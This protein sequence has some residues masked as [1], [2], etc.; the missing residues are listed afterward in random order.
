MAKILLHTLVFSPDSVSTSYL[1][2]DIAKEMKRLGHSITVL[3]T[4]PHYNLDEHS[5][6]LQPMQEIWKGLLYRSM[7]DSIPVWHVKIPLKG[8]K[9]SARL[10]DYLRFHIISLMVGTLILPSHD[11]VIAPSPPLT[12]GVIAWLMSLKW[13]A[14]SVYNVQEIY[15][16]F[17]INQG[18]MR[19][20]VMIQMMH[21]L[22]QFVY[23]QNKMIVP[24]SEWFRRI[25]KNR[26]VSD[27][28]LCVIPNFVDA[29]LYR[30]LPRNNAFARKHDLLD[31]FVVLYGGNVGASQDW[32][33][34][35]FAAEKLFDLPITFVIVGD[36]MRREWLE[37]E[38]TGRKLT[39][40]KFL[41]YHSRKSMP[42]IN[43]SSDIGII[44]MKATTTTDTFPSKIYTIMSCAKPAIVSADP[45]SELAWII[46]QSGCGRVVTPEDP[47]AY[48]NAIRQAFEERKNLPEEGKLG[49]KFVEQDYTKEVV[50]QKYSVLVQQLLK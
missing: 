3:T 27:D 8:Q 39:N 48:T 47:V 34:L 32:E 5:L 35:L 26:G 18:A 30:P 14:P 2:T 16:D 49:R 50:A 23:K 13:N 10:M 11:I 43:A 6:N 28:K 45:D 17:A 46:Q 19:N 1:M 24:I 44:P 29:Q 21:W 7:C 37:Q 25:I 12:I 15:P 20:P 33:S 31:T 41:G 9:I 40:V 42:E 4:T 36:G 38:I 22:E